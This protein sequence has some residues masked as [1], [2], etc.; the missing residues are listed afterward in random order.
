MT[1]R[2][3]AKSENIKSIVRLR[4]VQMSMKCIFVLKY[5]VNCAFEACTN[6]HE[7]YFRTKLPFLELDYLASAKCR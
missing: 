4:H 6:V 7:M 5:K 2:F 3:T 1:L